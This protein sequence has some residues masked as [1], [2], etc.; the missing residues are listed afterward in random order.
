MIKH[1]SY[2]TSPGYSVVI[3]FC[4]V[5]MKTVTFDLMLLPWKA[6]MRGGPVETRLPLWLHHQWSRVLTSE[7]ISVVT[8]GV[9]VFGF[10][11]VL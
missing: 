4:F 6:R 10:A 1:C 11:G 2:C 7:V 8:A 3:G 5:T 9:G